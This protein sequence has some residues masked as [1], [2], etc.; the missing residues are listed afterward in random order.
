MNAKEASEMLGITYRQLRYLVERIDAITKKETSQGYAHEFNRQDLLFLKLAAM[1]RA[2][3]IRL[4]D[5]N[6]AISLLEEAI[7][8]VKMLG[9]LIYRSDTFKISTDVYDEPPLEKGRWEWTPT[10]FRTSE[11][12]ANGMDESNMKILKHIPR[13]LYSVLAVFRELVGVDQLEF[14]FKKEKEVYEETQVK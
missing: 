12:L 4:N 9:T 6:D 10:I 1:M 8:T 13:G 14:D 11:N 7:K 2:D 3:G 5:I